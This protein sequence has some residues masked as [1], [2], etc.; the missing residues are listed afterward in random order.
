MVT[1]SMI[2]KNTE[3]QSQITL[4]ECH[5]RNYG[6]ALNKE[7][8]DALI[9]VFDEQAKRLVVCAGEKGASAWLSSLPL[10]NMGII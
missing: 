9:E 3:T 6:L 4:S 1:G 8:L 10:K 5:V 7:S 2:K